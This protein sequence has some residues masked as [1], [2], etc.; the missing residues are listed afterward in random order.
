VYAS[1]D[2]GE[3]WERLELPETRLYGVRL[4]ADS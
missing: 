1:H 3:A 2:A 4:L